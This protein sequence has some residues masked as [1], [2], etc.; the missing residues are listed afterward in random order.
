MYGFDNTEC[1][2][3]GCKNPIWP[4]KTL[5]YCNL[6]YQRF[7]RGRMAKNGDLLPL[8]EK[9]KKCES[10]GKVFILKK[11]ER[12]VRW[13]QSCRSEQYAKLQCEHNAGIY[14]RGQHGSHNSNKVKRKYIKN[15]LNKIIR[16]CELIKKHRQILDMRRSGSTYAEISKDFGCSR[17]NIH[18]ICSKYLHKHN[19]EKEIS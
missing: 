7:K 13:C 8:P 11:M 18:Q 10:C 2:I 17:Q 16:E 19:L 14:R 5:G 15:V 1:K 12:N 4:N 9:T 3:I 6:H